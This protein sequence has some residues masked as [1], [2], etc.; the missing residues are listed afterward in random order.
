MTVMLD[1]ATVADAD[2]EH[3]D[4]GNRKSIFDKPQQAN[5]TNSLLVDNAQTDNVKTS[6]YNWYYPPVHARGSNFITTDPELQ[7]PIITTDIGTGFSGKKR[8]ATILKRYGVSGTLWGEAGYDQLTDDNLWPFPHEDVIY[9]DFRQANPVPND[10]NANFLPSS[11]DTTRGFCA[12]G[13]TL[14]K[15]IW[16]Y[17]GA[18]IP[19]SVYTSDLLQ[20]SE[21]SG[22]GGGGGGCFIATAAFGSAIEKEVIS[23]CQFRDKYLLKNKFGKIFVGAYYYF[24]PAIAKVIKERTYL[25]ASIR[26]MLRPLIAGCE[27]LN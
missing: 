27:H 22:G 14:T 26:T 19:D 9:D 1:Q 7:Y 8:G 23:L 13:Q 15:Y 17:L 5:M 10:S 3:R 6:D 20:K 16:E 11:N 18:T 24:S 12:T 21:S 4:S 25:K 2:C